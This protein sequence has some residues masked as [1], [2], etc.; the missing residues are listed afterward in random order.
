VPP[1]ELSFAIVQGFV[2]VF[3]VV[4]IISVIRRYR[5]MPTYA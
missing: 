4:V 5:P 3:F 2:L 1:A